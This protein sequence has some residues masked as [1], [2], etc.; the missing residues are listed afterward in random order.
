MYFPRNRDMQF[1]SF[2]WQPLDAMDTHIDPLSAPDKH[3][4]YLDI[5]VA[6][7]CA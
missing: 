5:T 3:Q 2:S 1:L 4:P 6:P 7:P